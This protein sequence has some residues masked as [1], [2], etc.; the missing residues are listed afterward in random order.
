MAQ[1]EFAV[2]CA[3]R[4]VLA[5]DGGG[6]AAHER[7]LG[8]ALEERIP[9]RT[10]K[11]LDDIPTGTDEE[12][13][14]LLDDLAVAADRAV[15]TLQIAVDDEGEVVET[16]ARSEGQCTDR[17]GFVHLTIAEDPPDV[18]LI[19]RGETAMRE[20]THEARLVDGIHRADAHGARGKLPEIRHQ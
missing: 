19:G 16:L 5:I 20:V 13:L 2:L 15:E 7:V 18:A 11:H 10:P 4:L 3:E 6:K 14:E 9:V 8:I 1:V 17:L 12:R